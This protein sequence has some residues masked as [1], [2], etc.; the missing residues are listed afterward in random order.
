MPL[1]DVPVALMLVGLTAYM[2][3]AGADFGTGLWE[4]TAARDTFGVRL[5]DYAHDA[6]GPVW[7]AN[8]VWL[9]FVLAVFW[10]AYPIAFASVFTTLAVPLFVAVLGIILR[11]SAY[12]VRAVVRSDRER[13]L[14]DQIF[15]L[16]SIATPFALGAAIGGIASGRV[17]VGNAAGNLITSWLNPTSIIIG[18]IAVA[19]SGHL[20]AVY[21][22]ADARRQV[23]PRLLGAFR[24]RA[25]VSS[26]IT[27]ALALVGLAVMRADAPHLFSGLAQGAGLG[28]VVVSGAAGLITI[29]LVWFGRYE[30]ARYAGATAVAAI[31]AG[32]AAAQRPD[33][34]PGLSTQAASAGRATEVTV[35]VVIGLGALVLVPS[36]ILLFRLFLRGTFDPSAVRESIPARRERGRIPTSLVGILVVLLVVGSGLTVFADAGW[37]Q[38]LGVGAL[39]IFLAGGFIALATSVAGETSSGSSAGP[40]ELP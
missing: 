27:G 24:A 7:E 38:A 23:E 16:S 37:A 29:A 15:A 13:G 36:L 19:A 25:L 10:S 9:I 18:V 2:V 22:A 26:V 35:I 17:P 31:I 8:H 33:I 28:A 11:G 32:W 30:S 4:L 12:A 6:M 39:L 20:A 21:L 5:R 40:I 3:L 1:A 34:L 14:V